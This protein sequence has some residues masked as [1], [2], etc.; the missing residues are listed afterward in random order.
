MPL[1]PTRPQRAKKKGTDGKEKNTTSTTGTV[2]LEANY[3]NRQV[4]P[5]AAY[6]KLNEAQTV[7]Y[8]EKEGS[9][10]ID[11]RYPKLFDARYDA[12]V[13]RVITDKVACASSR[14]STLPATIPLSE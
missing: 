3:R 10:I 7:V 11:V 5:S 2:K 14:S 1:P 13:P 9:K 8:S 4:E 6:T 12:T